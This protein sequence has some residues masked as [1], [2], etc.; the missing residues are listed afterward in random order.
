MASPL[1]L[2]SQKQWPAALQVPQKQKIIIARIHEKIANQRKDFI[3]KESTKLTRLYDIICLEDIN[4]QNISQS[5]KLGKSTLDNG[6][7]MF[8]AR[9]EQKMLVEGKRVVKIDK[10]FPSSKMCRFCGYVN[11]NL[12][13]SD[14]VWTCE[15][16]AILNRDKN[17]AINIMNEGLKELT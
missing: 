17:A 5:L 13:L 15:C 7:G 9:L 2:P 4:L 1:L 3:E 16:E 12:K 10:W 8:R 11:K 14:R 6:F